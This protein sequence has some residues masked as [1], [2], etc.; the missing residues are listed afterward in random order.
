[1]ADKILSVSV[2]AYN[3][4]KTICE[5]LDVFCNFPSREKL[6]VIIVDDQSTDSTPEIAD[7]YA[8]EYPE[9]FTAVHKENGGWASTVVTGI[10]HAKGKY[11]KQLDGDDHYDPDS[12]DKFLKNL[13]ETDADLVITQYVTY[14]DVDG[15]VISVENRNPGVEPDI[16]YNLKDINDFA[17]FMHSLC[18][19]TQLLKEENIKLLEHRFYTDTEFVL[20]ACSGA[21]TVLFLD[22]PVY[23]YRRGVAGQSMSLQGLEKH[24]IDQ[25]MVIRELMEYEKEKVERDEIRRIFDKLLYGTCGWQYQIYF[26]LKPSF[27]HRRDLIS[28]DKFIKEH[29]P[30]VYNN[31]VFWEVRM[32]RKYHY[33]GYFLLAPHK[34]RKDNRFTKDGRLRY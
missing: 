12:L 34:F 18:V 2:A 21:H 23:Y 25:D 20:K 33:L 6:D 11:F 27:K 22:Y 1:M 29:A 30:D 13:E 19:R 7:R 9:T 24:Y 4:E 28:F 15:S 16:K 10:Q 8:R 14:D 17:P 32:F 5:T 31:A 3:V 26:Y